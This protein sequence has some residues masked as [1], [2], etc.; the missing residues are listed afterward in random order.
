M[1]LRFALAVLAMTAVHASLPA[2]AAGDPGTRSQTVQ[3][4]KGATSAQ[5]RGSIKGDAGVDYRIDAR[6]GQTL[7][8]AMK[9]SNAS[10]YFNINPPGSEVAM[11]VGSTSGS[12]ATVMLPADGIYVVRAYLM[13]NAAR[14]NEASTF[15]LTVGVTGKALAP[16]AASKDALIPGTKFHASAP[17]VCTPPFESRPQQCEAFVIRRGGD[18]TATVEVRAPNALLRRILFVGGVPVASDSTQAMAHSRDGDRTVVKF[19][20]DERYDLP[21]AL[22]RGG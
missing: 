16:L 8:V 22:I 19:G 12:E 3:F 7:S 17:T 15:T 9:A 11:F 20:T 14:R 1:T 6:A 2:H 10:T 21:D 13:R 18:G 4:A 5:L